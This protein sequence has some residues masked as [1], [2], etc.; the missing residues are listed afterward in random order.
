MGRTIPVNGRSM[1]AD[2]GRIPD[3]R[4]PDVSRRELDRSLVGAIETV[5]RLITGNG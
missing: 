1:R 5:A 4:G 3:A 2:R